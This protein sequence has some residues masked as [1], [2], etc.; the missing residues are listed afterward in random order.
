MSHLVTI[1]TQVRDVAAIA[2]ACQRLQLPPPMHGTAKLFAGQ[3]V[4][5]QIVQLSGWRFPVVCDTTTGD[6]KFDNF[7]GHWGD[8]QELDKFLQSYA[9]E[10]AKLEARRRGHS[11]TEQL[12]ADGSI[13]LTI[14]VAGGAA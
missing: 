8:Q 3:E 9:A 14:Q 12:L 6:T 5:G 10:K 4:T 1:R 2:A 7:N 13:K 11:V